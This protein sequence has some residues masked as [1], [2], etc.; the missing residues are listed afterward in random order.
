MKLYLVE[1][2]FPSLPDKDRCF[3]IKASSERAAKAKAAKV[4]EK[5]LLATPWGDSPEK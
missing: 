2:P 3:W 1:L 5:F 4:I